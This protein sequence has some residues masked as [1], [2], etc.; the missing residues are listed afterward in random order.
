MGWGLISAT[1][2]CL[3][4]FVANMGS[5]YLGATLN[6]NL[7]EYSLSGG[8]S[9][10]RSGNGSSG[11]R[12]LGE[13]S[14]VLKNISGSRPR[15]TGIMGGQ[16]ERRG[17][18]DTASIRSTSRVSN[19]GSQEFIIRKTGEYPIGYKAGESPQQNIGSAL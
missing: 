8:R 4:S 12:A 1:I 14:Y 16:E 7:G 10:D 19:D 17:Q 11:N 2:P 5:G 15:E 3:K 9:G 6:A 18:R 13:E